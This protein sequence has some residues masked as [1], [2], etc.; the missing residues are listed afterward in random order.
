[1]K[2]LIIAMLLIV[3]FGCKKESKPNEEE[4]VLGA[5]TLVKPNQNELCNSG[6]VIS[7]QVSQVKFEWLPAAN[8]KTYIL[9][10]KNLENGESAQYSS[11]NTSLDVRLARNTPFSWFVTAS[12]GVFST[13]SDIWRMYNSG[14]GTTSH[15]PYPADNMLPTMGTIVSPTAGKVLLSWVGSDVDGDIVDYDVFFGTTIAPSLLKS[16]LINNQ[17]EVSVAAKT[18]FYWKVITRDKNGNTSES[19]VYQ[20]TTI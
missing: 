9:T 3:T 11:A 2:K 16:N 13:K 17:L 12:S 19:I 14:I 18:K 4:S 10:I 20:F 5:V 6:V 15:I 1:M 7:D 8:A